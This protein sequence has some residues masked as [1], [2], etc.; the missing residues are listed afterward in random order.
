MWK[1]WLKNGIGKIENQCKDNGDRFLIKSRDGK[2]TKIE[3][4]RYNED[5]ESCKIY[6]EYE[7]YKEIIDLV[8]DIAKKKYDKN[9][10]KMTRAGLDHLLWYGYKGRLK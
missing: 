1:I 7:Q 8:I 6:K 9:G 2:Y 3:F 10:E 5:G 4:G